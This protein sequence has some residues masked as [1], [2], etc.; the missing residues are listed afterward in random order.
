MDN[1]YSENNGWQHYAVYENKPRTVQEA[2]IFNVYRDSEFIDD[3]EE[4]FPE[5]N[6]LLNTIKSIDVDEEKVKIRD[7]IRSLNPE[8]VKLLAKKYL[9]DDEDV[10]LFLTGDD[11]IWFFYR[12]D[13]WRPYELF[14]NKDGNITAK[15]NIDITKKAFIQMWEVVASRKR[16]DFKGKIPQPK[17]REHTNLLYAIFK[18]KEIRGEKFPQIYKQYKNKSLPYFEGEKPTEFNNV[19]KLAAYY[20]QNK[21]N[22]KN[23]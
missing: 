10:R 19:D 13:D 12:K 21:P 1:E 22:P 14:I 9:I 18:A 20:R 4:L 17:L 3:V 8:G 11:T 7:K 15:F 6:K 5:K 23:T 16:I 2:H